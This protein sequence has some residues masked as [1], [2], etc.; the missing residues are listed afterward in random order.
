VSGGPPDE[1]MQTVQFEMDVGASLLF[2]SPPVV[3]RV[4]GG[5]AFVDFNLSAFRSTRG[6]VET[7]NLTATDD[8]GLEN[9]GEDS[10]SFTVNFFN[11]F[12]PLKP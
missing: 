5:V 10:T 2:S 3:A 8:G 11:N 4:E 1:A 6:E 12:Q 9:G 7:F